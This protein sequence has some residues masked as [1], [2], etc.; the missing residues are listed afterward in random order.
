MSELTDFI[1]NCNSIEAF[2]KKIRINQR[3]LRIVD[4]KDK[5]LTVLIAKTDYAL[6]E[7]ADDTFK[8]NDT[9]QFI[10]PYGSNIGYQLE[11]IR[12]K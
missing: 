1:E 12:I 10:H 8:G 7:T 11:L 6:I 3:E 4:L 9:S 5:T 2:M